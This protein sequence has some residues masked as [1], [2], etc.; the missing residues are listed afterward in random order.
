MVKLKIRRFTLIFT[1]EPKSERGFCLFSVTKR[2]TLSPLT[3][4]PIKY[5]KLAPLAL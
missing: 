2:S 5:T 1:P 4:A 3:L